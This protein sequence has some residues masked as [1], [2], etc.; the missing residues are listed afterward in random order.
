[1][2]GDA[3]E[4]DAG[5][6]TNGIEGLAEKVFV[7]VVELDVV[8]AC[9]AGIQADSLSHNVGDGFRLEFTTLLRGASTAFVMV[10]D[11][12]REFMNQGGEF[13]GWVKALLQHNGAAL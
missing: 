9:R 5:R 13:L 2:L 10:K 4:N 11:L 8:G 12:V 6:L 1:V 3:F 7:T